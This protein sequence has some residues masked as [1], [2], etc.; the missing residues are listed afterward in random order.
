MSVSHRRMRMHALAAATAVAISALAAPAFAAERLN[1]S[2]RESGAQYD[3]FIVKY[4]DGTA[5]R[6][7][8]TKAKAALVRATKAG[9]AGKDLALVHL[10]RMALGADVVKADR[11]LDRAESESLMLEIAA[12]NPATKY[13]GGEG[14]AREN[15]A[16]HHCT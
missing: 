2:G 6:S 7:D 12:L 10:R 16:D 13:T 4:K 15:E 1:L 9:V 5:E 11:K 3:R 8:A 14:R